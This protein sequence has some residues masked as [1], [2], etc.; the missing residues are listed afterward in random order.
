MFKLAHVNLV[1]ASPLEAAEFYKRHLLPDGEIVTLG[2]SVHLRD[3][4]GSDIAFI[5]GNPSPWKGGAHHGFLAGGVNQI[6]ALRDAIASEGLVLTEDCD[7]VDFR[8]IKFLD[9]DGYECEVFW[10]KGW[11]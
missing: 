3:A 6:D 7:E 4:D 2:N 8:S 1:V 9:P 10:E 5:E 11:P